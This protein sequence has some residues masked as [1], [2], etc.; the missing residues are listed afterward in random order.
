M[1]RPRALDEA[2]QNLKRAAESQPTPAAQERS[3]YLAI[4]IEDAAAPPNETKVIDLANEFLQKHRGSSFVSDVRLKLAETYFRGG[5]FASA[6]TQFTLLAQENPDGPLTEKAQFFAAQSARQSM[7]AGAL[8]RALVLFD[9][10]VKKNGELKWAARNEQA[11]I[12]RKLGK[13]DDAV[14]LYDEVLKGDAKGPEKRE[15]LCGKGDILYEQGASNPE[16]YKRA[17][18]NLRSARGA[19]RSSVR[20]GATRRCAKRECARRS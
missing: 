13:N 4:W 14:T 6:Q 12:E 9:E 5:D 16:N 1:L 2:R 19:K 17:G 20:T 18:G 7:A 10:V 3:D 8:D 15:A 11:V